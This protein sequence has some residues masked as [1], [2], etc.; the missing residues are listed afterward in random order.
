MQP[1]VLQTDL[2]IEPVLICPQFS[3]DS[4]SPQIPKLCITK[5]V[6][7][8]NTHITRLSVTKIPSSSVAQ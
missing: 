8:Q 1:S 4:T 3:T 5:A 7:S 6:L 2:D